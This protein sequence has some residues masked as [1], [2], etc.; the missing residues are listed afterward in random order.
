FQEALTR[1]ALVRNGV[2]EER[3]FWGRTLAG[4]DAEGGIDTDLVLGDNPQRPAQVIQVRHSGSSK[5][6]EKKF[7]RAVH[8][9]VT[10]KALHSPAPVAVSVIFEDALKEGLHRAEV[11]AF[12]A[13]LRLPDARYGRVLIDR[14]QSL[15]HARLTS[16][17]GTSVAG[18]REAYR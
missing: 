12:D 10:V 11:A 4:G 1:L 5:E 9:L 8:E 18:K 13:V 15:T 7:W 2:A 3:I 16:T 17:R 14:C 6:Q